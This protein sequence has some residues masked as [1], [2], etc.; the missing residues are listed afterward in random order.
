[1]FQ[2]VF[3]YGAA[4]AVAAVTLLPDLAPGQAPSQLGGSNGSYQTSGPARDDVPA[5]I[6]VRV[7][8]GADLWFNG[9]KMS[10]TGHVRVFHSPPLTPRVRYVY[11]VRARWLENGRP[12]TQTQSVAVYAGEPVDVDFPIAPGI[13]AQRYWMRIAATNK[14]R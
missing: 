4:L 2:K 7:P 10:P 6:T 13:E 5:Y 3:P 9:L 14:G 12:V 11:E 1:M 8:P